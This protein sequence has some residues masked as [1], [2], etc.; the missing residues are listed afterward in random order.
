MNTFDSICARRGSPIAVLEITPHPKRDPRSAECVANP[1]PVLVAV[2]KIPDD[3]EGGV[4]VCGTYSAAAGSEWHLNK[5]ERQAVAH[6]LGKLE[7]S[8]EQ[9]WIAMK[10]LALTM[11]RPWQAEEA[12]VKIEALRNQK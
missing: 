4:L 6:L 12:L 7:A 9:L 11:P 2:W 5:G 10:A 1:D 3:Y 8:E